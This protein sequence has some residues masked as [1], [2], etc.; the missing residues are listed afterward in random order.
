M[1]KFWSPDLFQRQ[2][3][4]VVQCA[5]VN[6]TYYKNDTEARQSAKR[7]IECYASH[8]ENMCPDSRSKLAQRFTSHVNS[9]TWV[10]SNHCARLVIGIF[11]VISDIE[12]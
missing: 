3:L 9:A 11:R 5:A 12:S 4:T 2:C 6:D 10:R 1:K 8:L 7:V